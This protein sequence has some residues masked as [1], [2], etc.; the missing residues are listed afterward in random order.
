MIERAYPPS[1]G[2]S[3]KLPVFLLGLGFAAF[4]AVCVGLLGGFLHPGYASSEAAE[5]ALDLPV[6]VTT[7]AK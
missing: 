6:L 3:L 7:P 1:K 2:S 5:R 4:C